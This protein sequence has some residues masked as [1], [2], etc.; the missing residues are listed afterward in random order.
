[1]EIYGQKKREREKREREKRE[2]KERKKKEIRDSAKNVV[3][4]ILVKLSVSSQIKKTARGVV[5][6]CTKSLSVGEEL[7]SIDVRLVSN[8]SLD[9][10]TGANVPDLGS[11][12]AGSRHKDVLLRE[13]REAE[14]KGRNRNM[15]KIK[16]NIKIKRKE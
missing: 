7:D 15:G 1:L 3:M 12:I 5:G 10:F 16:I 14:E 2:K 9:T 13:K 4:C 11:G 6:S 8:K